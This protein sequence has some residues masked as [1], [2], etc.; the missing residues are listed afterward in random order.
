MKVSYKKIDSTLSLLKKIIA[1]LLY[2]FSAVSLLVATGFLYGTYRG[3]SFVIDTLL[4]S[5]VYLVL[6]SM[7]FFFAQKILG[8]SN[9]E[10][11]KIGFHLFLLV[12][13]ALVIGVYVFAQIMHGLGA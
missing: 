5:L 12:I 8:Y 10:T 11:T 2:L 13:A 6:S 1:G 4:Y 7:S 9:T 3:E